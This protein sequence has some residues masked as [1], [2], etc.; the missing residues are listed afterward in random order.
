MMQ[1]DVLGFDAS[2]SE[3]NVIMS[4]VNDRSSHTLQSVISE[5]IKNQN[6]ESNS[7]SVVVKTV[8][9]RYLSATAVCI[10]LFHPSVLPVAT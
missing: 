4:V 5:I 8:C 1:V 3:V 9:E 2:T 6:G 10:F 7:A